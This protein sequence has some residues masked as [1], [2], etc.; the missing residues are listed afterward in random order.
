MD[1]FILRH[2]KAGQSSEDPDDSERALTGPGREEIRD[3][4]RW[5]RRERLRFGVIASSPLIRASET[6]GI[7]ARILDR[8]DR[9]VIWDEL[10]PGGDPD[11]I[12]Y[13][14]AQSGKETTVLIVGHEPD[15]SGLVGRI[16][17]QSGGPASLVIAKGGLAKIRNFSFDS[18]PSGNLQWLLTPKQ[19]LAM[20]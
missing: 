12:C 11:T 1:L 4:A 18:Q 10:A 8:K 13:R 20:R 14:A 15:L 3:I 7:V 9:L 19:M 16:I 5:M 2:G 17:S 6:A